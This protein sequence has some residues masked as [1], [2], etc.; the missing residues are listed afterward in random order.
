MQLFKRDSS[1]GFDAVQ[2][3]RKLINI[4]VLTSWVLA[5][6]ITASQAHVHSSEHSVIQSK[7]LHSASLG[8]AEADDPHIVRVV[9]SYESG[10]VV[11]SSKHMVLLD[12]SHPDPQQS[13]NKVCCKDMNC[14]SGDVVQAGSFGHSSGFDDLFFVMQAHHGSLVILTDSPPPKFLI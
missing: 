13:N 3:L 1:V 5:Q 12:T 10:N 8:H 4:L 6:A 14:Q 9:P 7:K 2:G 11:A